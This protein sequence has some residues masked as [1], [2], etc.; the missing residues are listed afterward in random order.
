MDRLKRI[1]SYAIRTKN[2]AIRLRTDQPEYS[3][4][5]DQDFDWAYSV[6]GNVQEILPDDMPD[7]LGKAVSTIDVNLNH[8]LATG[9]SLTGCLHFV[10]KTP[11]DWYS[12]KQATVETATYGSEFVAA[13]SA[14]EQIMDIR[15]TLP[16]PSYLVTIDL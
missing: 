4:L 7:P 15:Q 13:K 6:Y 3:S 2:Y 16:N 12:K 9:K 10:N 1:Y 14:A 11:V 8:C 5:P